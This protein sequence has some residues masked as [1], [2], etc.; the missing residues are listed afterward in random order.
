MRKSY[1][2]PATCLIFLLSVSFPAHAGEQAFPQGD[3]TAGKAMFDM[4]CKYCHRSDYD[5]KYGP[6]LKGISER[7]DE[8]W[9][10]RWLRDPSVMVKTDEHAKALRESN[11]YNMTM[12]AIPAMK[13]P[14]ARA[15]VIAYL[16]TLK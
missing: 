15:D 16:K 9:L 4:V 1:G 5:D 3:A 14:Q 12:P 2:I 10:H 6:G 7:V 13:D 11:A 8:G